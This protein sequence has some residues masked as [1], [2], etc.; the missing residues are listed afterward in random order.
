MRR[1]CPS[2]CAPSGPCS[3]GW[4]RT[5][6]ATRASASSSTSARG[7]PRRTTCTR[8]RRRSRPRRA[9]ST[10]TTTRSCWRTPVL[11]K[12][13]G[14]GA[15]AFIQADLRDPDSIVDDP[16]LSKV[17]DPAAPVALLLIGIVHHLRDEERPYELVERLVSRL[18]G[19]SYLAVVTPSAASDPPM[20][21]SLAATAERSGIPYVPRS[22]ADVE[23]FF[24]GLELVEPGVAPILGWRPDDDP[25]DVNAVHG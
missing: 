24:G 11:M 14:E 12:T 6:S 21:A 9:C 20:M 22:K 19:G 5:W 8:W 16:T 13:T 3:R 1:P 18:P 23:R 17:L 4:S 2:W 10:S 25:A 7:S 15:T